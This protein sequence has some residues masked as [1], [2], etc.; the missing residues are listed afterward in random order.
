VAGFL[1]KEQLL[2]ISDE[3]IY[4]HIWNDRRCGGTL[5]SICVAHASAA[6]ANPLCQYDV[7]HLPS[8]N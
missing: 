2:W 6:S 5:Q 4:R 1:R 7:R 8:M 3:T